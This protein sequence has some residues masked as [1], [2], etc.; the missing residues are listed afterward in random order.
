V[1]G[2]L[3]ILEC[4]RKFGVENLVYASSSSVYGAN[5]EMPL[6]E[7]QEVSRPLSL[8][9]AT[10]AA[11][12]LMAHA[13]SHL[14]DIPMTGLRFFTVYGTH[15]RPDMAIYTF[16][17][18]IMNGETLELYNHGGM[19]RDFTYVDDVVDGILRALMKPQK[20]AIYNLGKGKADEITYVVN[21][22]E[23]E[24]GKMAKIEPVSMHK[25]DVPMTL[26]DISKAKAEL[27]YEPKTSIEEGIHKFCNWFKVHKYAI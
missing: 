27:G 4:A 21:R 24:L 7:D 8:Y 12:E 16:A 2:F 13:Y 15:S 3:N 20:N 11:N 22:L 23:H 5:A 9:A 1:T 14:F 6:S 17:E 25:A 10:K 19:V 18:K 26:A